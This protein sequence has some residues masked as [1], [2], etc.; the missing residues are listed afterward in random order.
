MTADKHSDV[1]KIG[2]VGA[3]I[4]GITATL[5]LLNAGY[6]VCLFEKSSG[7]SA[8]SEADRVEGFGLGGRSATRR[9][10]AGSFDHGPPG[11]TASDPMFRAVVDSAAESG[12]AA[13]WPDGEADLLS[14]RDGPAFVGLPGASGFPRGLIA[15]SGLDPA[16]D[17]W[18]SDGRLSRR[19]ACLAIEAD[20]R[21]EA[22]GWTIASSGAGEDLTSAIAAMI[23]AVPAPQAAALLAPLDEPAVQAALASVEMAPM[24]TAMVAFETALPAAADRASHPAIAKALR[25][26]SMPGRHGDT[27][28]WVLHATEVWSREHLDREKDAIAEEL[29]AAWGETVGP[30]SLTH[31]LA[32]HRWRYA[33]TKTPLGQPCL[34][35]AATRLG[36]CGD[37]CLG[38][39]VEHAWRSGRA[40]AAQV[41]ASLD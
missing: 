4:A 10:S 39:G 7:R 14:G 1:P 27:D 28:R 23:L 13:D 31:Y 18:G 29:L 38:D 40:M 2:V 12:W 24:L 37:W 34:W 26:S 32:G 6:R 17:D 36:L 25:L 22:T 11:F 9:S 15:A 41:I 20:D 5:A 19:G 33:L 3:G 35:D 16:A 30:L 21:S 8:R